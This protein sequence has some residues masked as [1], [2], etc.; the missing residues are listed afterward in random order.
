MHAT[1]TLALYVFLIVGVLTAAGCAGPKETTERSKPPTAAPAPAPK[2]APAAPRRRT[3]Q[4]FR[5]QIQ[6]TPQ[7]AQ[8]DQAVSRVSAWWRSLPPAQRPAGLNGKTAPVYVQ[9]KQPYYR[10]RVGNF[11]TRAAA[12]QAL[13]KLAAQYPTAFIVPETVTVVQ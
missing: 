8:A 13:R 5:V 1:R 2:K 3:V 6:Q 10:V 11:A 9:W 4:G 7:K 12:E